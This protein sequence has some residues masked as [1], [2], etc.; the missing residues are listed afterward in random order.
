MWFGILAGSKH[1][2]ILNWSTSSKLSVE[3]FC[4]VEWQVKLFRSVKKKFILTEEK[5]RKITLH[6]NHFALLC[7]RTYLIKYIFMEKFCIP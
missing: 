2:N 6:K 5:C 3:V 7:P 1:K 4:E